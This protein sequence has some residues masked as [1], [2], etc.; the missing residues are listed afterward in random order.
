MAFEVWCAQWFNGAIAVKSGNN[1]SKKLNTFSISNTPNNTLVNTTTTTM[2]TNMPQS[3]GSQP[4]MTES[5]SETAPSEP[6]IDESSTPQTAE[7]NSM[8]VTRQTVLET[9]ENDN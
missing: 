8:I 9:V 1:T 5:G 6:V 4:K 3:Q 7:Q 2:P